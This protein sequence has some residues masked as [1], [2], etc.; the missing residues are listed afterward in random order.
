MEKFNSFFKE[1]NGLRMT[2]QKPIHYFVCSKGPYS[3]HFDCGT[4]GN[5]IVEYFD[6]EEN[7]DLA[8]F[9]E[10]VKSKP[11]CVQKHFI[12]CEGTEYCAV[13]T[14]NVE[15]TYVFSSRLKR[16]FAPKLA[17]GTVTID[18]LIEEDKR[19]EDLA[20][21]LESQPG[22]KLR[23]SNGKVIPDGKEFAIQIL[24]NPE[25]ESDEKDEE[26]TEGLSKE[27]LLF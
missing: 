9:A 11:N 6:S 13:E 23:D 27:E 15:L 21:K 5:T 26:E 14:D 16:R 12:V 7:V 2:E 4:E 1:V 19:L 10:I 17:A 18:M 24:P 3:L 8:K 25:E 22:F 20:I